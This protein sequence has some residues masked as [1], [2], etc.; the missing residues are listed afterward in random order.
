MPSPRLLVSEILTL[1]SLPTSTGLRKPPELL[2]P[3][4]PRLPYP[5]RC[6]KLNYYHTSYRKFYPMKRTFPE[7]YLKGRN[8]FYVVLA[9]F[10]FVS[11]RLPIQVS[12]ESGA[13][14]SEPRVF[15]DRSLLV[16]SHFS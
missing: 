12:Y 11:T 6:P 15:L 7:G 1:Y 14:V 10:S 16:P 5:P 13:G 9:A 8:A 2:P 3:K 4:P